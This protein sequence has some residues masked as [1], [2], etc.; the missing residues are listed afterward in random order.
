MK[1]FLTVE[2]IGLNYELWLTM[3]CCYSRVAQS[4]NI[5]RLCA[6]VPG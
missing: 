4:A 1:D 6:K 2:G 3:R 5:E